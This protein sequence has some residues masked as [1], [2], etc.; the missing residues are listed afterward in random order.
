MSDPIQLLNTKVEI[1]STFGASKAIT[2]ISKATEAVVDCVGHGFTVGDPV[3]IDGVVG[4]SQINKR[5][6]R[7]KASPTTD[8]FTCEGLDS[9]AFST[10]LSGGTAIE[11]TGF[12]AFSTL[13]NFD[14]P[15][16]QPNPEDI[17]TIHALT[18]VE[19]FGLDAAPTVSFNTHA[20]PLDA[21][22]TEVR[23]TALAKDNRTYRVTFQ[24]G[25][26]MLFNGKT[27]G[28]RGISGAAGAVASGT[29]SIK[30]VQTEQVFAS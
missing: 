9:T 4:M 28:G 27:A 10:W 16:P 8:S 3:V 15:E 5:V 13:T 14:Y 19:I 20:V 26:V 2:G 6:I 11:S 22:I 30:L 7:V 23:K 1:N 24:N 18:K 21:T 29:I 25:N 12:L 17:T